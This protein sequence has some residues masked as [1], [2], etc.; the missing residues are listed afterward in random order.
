MGFSFFPKTPKF[1]DLFLKQN[2]LIRQAALTLNSLF[3]DFI[4]IADKCSVITDLESQGNEISDEITRQL[5]LS[6]ITPIDRED[7]HDIN[8]AQE[9]LLNSIK[10]ISSRVS[11]YQS[12]GINKTSISLIENFK[13][14]IEETVQMFIK[15]KIKK[16]ADEHHKK[17]KNIKFQS[18]LLL[19]VALGE[20][21]ETQIINHSQT[22]YILIWTQ[23][24]D[25]IEQA[26]SA[27]EIL[28][29][30]LEGVSLKNV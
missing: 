10:A 28:G 30:I 4:S 23:I 26:I 24:Y 22:T 13:E 6:F 5:S 15:I 1:F 14:I 2:E 29:N 18:D 16:E 9:N 3:S 8:I 27:A 11:L 7:I 20:L 25:R 17:I 19:L 12:N 21:Y